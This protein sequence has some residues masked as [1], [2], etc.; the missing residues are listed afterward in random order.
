MS[1]STLYLYSMILVGRT[2]MHMPDLLQDTVRVP[3]WTF[4]KWRLQGA[5]VA[6][7]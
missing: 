2:Y 7:V 1:E 3:G 5:G 4:A 6:V